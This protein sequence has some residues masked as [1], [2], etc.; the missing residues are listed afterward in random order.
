MNSNKNNDTLKEHDSVVL[1]VDVSPINKGT[2]GVI[3]YDYEHSGM[4]EVE[5]FDIDGNTIGVERIFKGD[6][7]KLV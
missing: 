6:L 7:E 4:Y 2:K 5:F 1:M 3:V